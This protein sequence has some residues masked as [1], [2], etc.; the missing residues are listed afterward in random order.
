MTTGWRESPAERCHPADRSRRPAT[1]GPQRAPRSV[2]DRRRDRSEHDRRHQCGRGFR[3]HRQLPRRAE[4]RV[5][6]KWRDR[7]PQPGHRWEAGDG[8]IG[9]HLRHQ[10]GRHGQAGQ[11]VPAQPAPLV[12]P[13]LRDSRRPFGQCHRGK[14]SATRNNN[15]GRNASH[16]RPECT[17]DRQ[18]GGEGH[19]HQFLD[20]RKTPVKYHLAAG[21]RPRRDINTPASPKTSGT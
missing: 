10:I 12:S 7:R 2:P 14:D 13:E 18:Q 6:G 1:P 3:S 4:Y 20:E 17:Y 16:S 19:Q 8:R 5:E 11:D 15:C 9:H 21:C